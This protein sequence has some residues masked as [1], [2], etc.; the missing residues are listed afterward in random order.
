MRISVIGTG[1]LGATHAA[2]LAHWGHEVVGV[3]ADRERLEQLVAGS[4]PFHEPGL[5]ELVADGVRAGR[6]R[7]S[8][9]IGAVA[10]CEVHFLCVGTP[11]R[12]DG[13][14]ADLSALWSA[15]ESLAPHV[16][17]DDLVVGKSTVPVGTA[18]ELSER[19]RAWCGH[20]VRVAWNPEFLRESQAVHDSLQPDRLVLGLTD[21]ADGRVLRA[22]YATLLADGVPLVDTSL[23]TAE[24]AKSAANL[25][26]AARISMVNV[27][28]ETCERAGADASDLVSILATDPRIGS[29][30]LVPG[31]GYGGGCLPKDSR[32]FADRADQLGVFGADELVADIDKVNLHQRTR[33]VDTAVHMLGDRP[34]GRRV[35]VL[36]AAF[37]AD[38]DDIRESPAL[39]VACRLRERGADV[40]VYDPRAGENVRRSAPELPVADSAVEACEGAEL[41]M[42]LT[43]WSEFGDIDPSSLASVVREQAVIDGRQVLDHAKWQSAGW[44]IYT[45]GSGRRPQCAS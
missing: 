19:M 16:R 33:T 23:E 18:R 28:A 42:V 26:L 17:P 15:A 38:S 4:V 3:D 27:L 43:D 1:Y 9:D 44:E 5:D 29:E 41:V 22:V 2:C 24:L 32:A 12:E 14:Q 11:Q 36:G 35:A 13:P 10:G 40:V 34:E 7:F 37:K 20:E 31:V 45:L 25:M 30:M 21:P 6:L 8:D 39:E